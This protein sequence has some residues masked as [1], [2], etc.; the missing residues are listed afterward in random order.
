MNY[1]LFPFLLSIF[2]YMPSTS[3]RQAIDCNKGSNILNRLEENFNNGIY[4][5]PAKKVKVYPMKV[6]NAKHKIKRQNKEIKYMIR[7]T[8]IKC[9]ED[10]H[11]GYIITQE[12]LNK[13]RIWLNANCLNK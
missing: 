11:G 4:V 7:L 13:W 5:Y 6:G 12:T 2:T 3:T 1:L 8:N 10:T 9:D